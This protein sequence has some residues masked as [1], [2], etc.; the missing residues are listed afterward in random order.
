[1]KIRIAQ[2][3]P[4]VGDVAGNLEKHVAVVRK[5]ITAGDNLVVFPELSL[6][7]YPPKDLLLHPDFVSA[8]FCAEAELAK[9]STHEMG[10]VFGTVRRVLWPDGKPLQ[11]VA[12]F[13][14]DGVVQARIAKRLLPTYDVFDEVRYFDP[15]RAAAPVRFMGQMIGLSVCEDIWNDKGFW[16]TRLY[17]S[18]PIQDL[19][20]DGASII[21]NISA[22]P[23]SIGK[24]V[25]REKMLCHAASKYRRPIVYVNQVGGND[26]VIYD[27][28]SM[29]IAPGGYVVAECEAFVEDSISVEPFVPDLPL[30]SPVRE[31]ES[32]EIFDALVLG[33]RDYVTK[34]GFRTVVLGLSGGIDSAVVAA[35]A[36][37][38]LGGTRVTGILMP[39]EFSS[40]GSVK[41]AIAL[42]NALGINYKVI[43]I[44]AM[45]ETAL[46]S[47]DIPLESWTTL[48]PV[49]YHAYHHHKVELWEENLQAR[50]RGMILMAYS[51]KYGHMLLTTG[52][53]S[54]IAMGYCTLY[55]DTCGG[56]AA[57]S[58]VFKTKVFALA[59]HINKVKGRE[60]IPE[61][62]ISKAPSAE[63]RPG[64]FD[65]ESLPP[66]ADLDEVLAMYIEEDANIAAIAEK[67]GKTKEFVTGIVSKVDKNE[68][69]RKQLAPGL[70]VTKK[71]FGC[72][73][74]MP[75]A[76][77]WKL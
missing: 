5:A 43:P 71:A 74:V 21:I 31:D 14:S 49:T 60:V 9:M 17:D 76:Q 47:F 45:H 4:V 44:K 72:G 69:K 67:T 13:A 52:N 59:R 75:I 77:G 7:G 40:D 1:M 36:A 25:V 22:S 18:D 54:E 24:P 57:I 55:G 51:N 8:M 62:T 64:Q 6:C 53:K 58:D 29:V 32:A 15:G 68:Y 50:I 61:A 30:S 38:A 66:Y 42:G 10:I 39:S 19:V 56:L 41:D 3:N 20:N 28:R 2:I 73:R 16:G 27:G 48:D 34:C 35:I 70:R 37:E 33:M 23:F 63:L 12:A 46:G 26:D 11:N 65:Q